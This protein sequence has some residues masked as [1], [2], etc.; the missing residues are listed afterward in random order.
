[1]AVRA[2]AEG[3]YRFAETKLSWTQIV[4]SQVNAESEGLGKIPLLAYWG[5]DCGLGTC[6][7]DD[8]KLINDIC[9]FPLGTFHVLLESVPSIDACKLSI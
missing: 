8:S 9:T 6:I 4:D 3:P 2:E 7:F 1:M 5:A